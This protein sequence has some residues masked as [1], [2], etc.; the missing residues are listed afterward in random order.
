[1]NAKATENVVWTEKYRPQTFDEIVGQ[2]S[3]ISK[4]KSFVEKGE[5]PHLLF[6]GPPGSGKTTT[7]LV[8]AKTLF[9]DDWRDQILELNAS[10]ERGID[11]IRVKVKNFARTMKNPKYP[12]K[13]IYLDESDALTTQA[14][15][16]LRRTMEMYSGDTR[17]ILSCNYLS[18]IID[19]I[20]SRCAVFKFRRLSKESIFELIDKIAKREH[21]SVGE[22]AKNALYDISFGDCRKLENIL[23]SASYLG[24][25]DAKIVYD[26]AAVAKPD[27][28]KN[29]LSA[30]IKDK[31][32]FKALSALDY[33]IKQY[34]LSGIDLIKQIES[35]VESMDID[36][37]EK[38]KVFD[39]AALTESNLVS[40][41]DE[42]V[43]LKGF[44]AR[45]MR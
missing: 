5:M 39:E 45:L 6:A 7:A 38:I 24:K 41:C 40:G 19:P 13:I 35:V 20:Q 22:D 36:D 14:Q 18:K 1:M 17:F 31:N 4:I 37:N 16:A 27:E 23:Q 3:I 2:D 43:Q 33:V 8:I 10:D 42:E 15:Q 44:L 30:V 28:I 32:Y 21:I 34:A 26:L 9:G 29:I 25:I 11:V 12:F